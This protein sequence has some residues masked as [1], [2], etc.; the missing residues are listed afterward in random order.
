LSI[1]S[2][3]TDRCENSETIKEQKYTGDKLDERRTKGE[4]TKGV[5]MHL[6]I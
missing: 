4:N 3:A 6:A 1:S 5:T 2:R